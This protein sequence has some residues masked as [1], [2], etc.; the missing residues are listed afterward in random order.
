MFYQKLKKIEQSIQGCEYSDG[1][2]AY[3]LGIDILDSSI[4]LDRAVKKR[5]LEL[6]AII[7]T[8]IDIVI[9]Q[10]Q[11]PEEELLQICT[12]WHFDEKIC[13]EILSLVDENVKLYRCCEESEYVAKGNI[14]D[15]FRIIEKGPERVLLDYYI[16]D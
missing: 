9:T 3:C 8:E 7:S 16:V 6:N 10:I 14:V 1:G 13:N 12:A 15:V 5:L 2:V 4:T 11:H